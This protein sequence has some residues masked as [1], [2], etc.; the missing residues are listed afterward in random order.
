MSEHQETVV[1]WAQRNIA[2]TYSTTEEAAQR[3]ALAAQTCNLVGGAS[4]CPLKLG[5][6]ILILVVPIKR[7]NTYPTNK[8][9]KIIAKGGQPDTQAAD[10]EPPKWGPGKADLLALAAAAGVEWTECER[11]DNRSDPHFCHYKVTGR[12]RV[13]DGSWRTI[14]DE[15]DVDL[16]DG[17][18]QTA[19]MS[20]FRIKGLREN[21]IRLAITKARL[22]AVRGAFGVP[23]SMTAEDLDKPWVFSR[24]I[25]TGHSDDPAIR[26]LFAQV[27]AYQQLAATNALYGNAALPAL[28]G[29]PTV[30]PALP[31]GHQ[32]AAALPAAHVDF[33]ENDLPDEP[34]PPPPPPKAPPPAQKAP[35]PQQQQQRQQ[36]GQSGR[37]RT[38]FQVPGG[39]EKGADLAD[40]S[41]ETLKWWCSK[42]GKDL[43]EGTSNPKFAA[44]DEKLHRALVDQIASRSGQQEF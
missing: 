8:T 2:G 31:A 15:R 12:Y 40:A 37:P 43:S 28:P 10:Y 42:I 3:L 1:E 22:R 5:H 17:S 26:Q 13:I 36:S 25:F 27:V 18:P 19:G 11:L 4:V 38:G 20:D 34:P 30:G 7:D 32:P 39:K 23:H 16:R 41:I 14:S 6:Q 21:M 44:Q 9:A 29:M 35:P 33:D 24:M